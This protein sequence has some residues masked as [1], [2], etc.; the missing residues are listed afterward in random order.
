MSVDTF[1]TYAWYIP[2]SSTLKRTTAGPI[3]PA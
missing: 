1:I 3:L 2:A